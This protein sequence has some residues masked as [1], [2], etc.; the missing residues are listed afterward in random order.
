[1]KSFLTINS[2]Y[3]IFFLWELLGIFSFFLIKYW[4][5]NINNNKSAFKALIWNRVGDIIFIY[6]LIVYDSNSY[7]ISHLTNNSYLYYFILSIKSVQF[8][9]IL[10]LLS[11]MSTPT[12]VSALLH[13]SSMVCVGWYITYKLNITIPNYFLIYFLVLSLFIIS[14][15][16]IKKLLA[17]STSLNLFLM[18]ISKNYIGWIHMINHGLFKSLLFL[19]SGYILHFNSDLRLLS[20]FLHPF[21]F[22]LFL[23]LFIPL[24]FILLSLS[25][26]YIYLSANLYLYLILFFFLSSFFL[27]KLSYYFFLSFPSFNYYL[28]FNSNLFFIFSISLFT[29]LSFYLPYNYFSL[30]IDLLPFLFLLLNTNYPFSLNLIFHL[31]NIFSYLFYYFFLSFFSLFYLSIELGFFTF[32]L[33][34]FSINI[35]SPLGYIC[36]YI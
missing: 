7:L 1:M 24:P 36:Y 30:F 34:L 33:F 2:L 20:I 27:S 28:S 29:C 16:D 25:K 9:G 11:A 31:E 10:W 8:L 6:F 19:L 3:T 14:F 4:D 12:P 21:L 15:Y 22:K 18:F 5:K 32:S 26:D 23:L 13:S 35:L 17:I